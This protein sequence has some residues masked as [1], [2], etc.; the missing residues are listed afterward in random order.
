VVRPALAIREELSDRRG[1]SRRLWPAGPSGRGTRRRP[2]G[3][4]MDRQMRV[5]LRDFPASGDR[6]RPHGASAAHW[7]DRDR[8]ARELLG[9]GHGGGPADLRARISSGRHS[10]AV[11]CGGRPFGCRGGLSGCSESCRGRCDDPCPGARSLI[12]VRGQHRLRALLAREVPWTRNGA[13][14]GRRM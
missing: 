9:M 8:G 3:A 4:G 13:E 12:F 1:E 2:R 10:V 6:G 5:R 14:L 11:R 7:Q